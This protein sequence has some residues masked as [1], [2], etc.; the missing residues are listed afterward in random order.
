[1]IH[2]TKFQSNTW[3]KQFLIVLCTRFGSNLV[4]KSNSP[5]KVNIFM[6][7]VGRVPKKRRKK[8]TVVVSYSLCSSFL[9]GRRPI[10]SVPLNVPIVA[11]VGNTSLCSLLTVPGIRFSYLTDQRNISNL[12]HAQQLRLALS[13]T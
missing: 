11:I 2:Q 4:S 13:D 12:A 1:M 6:W 10:S 7:M 3:Q 5:S 9:S 8:S